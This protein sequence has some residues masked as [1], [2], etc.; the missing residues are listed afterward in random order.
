MLQDETYKSQSL[1]TAFSKNIEQF[2]N[3]NKIRKQKDEIKK[4]R[5]NSRFLHV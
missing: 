4:Y 1:I 5:R 3:K 2:V